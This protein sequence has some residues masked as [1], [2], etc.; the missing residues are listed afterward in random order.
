[1]NNADFMNINAIE[2]VYVAEVRFKKKSN[3]LFPM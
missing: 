1:M 2:Y 3:D